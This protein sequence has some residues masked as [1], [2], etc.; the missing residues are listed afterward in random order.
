MGIAEERELSVNGTA[1]EG[2]QA[3]EILLQH[4]HV[5]LL[6]GWRDLLGQGDQEQHPPHLLQLAGEH[7][8]EKT[9]RD[10]FSS[11][12]SKSSLKCVCTSPGSFLQLS[13]M[14]GCCTPGSEDH[15]EILRASAT[16]SR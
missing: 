10:L 7:L 15:G 14:G 8:A 11:A 3:E 12:E 9:D 4:G 5:G 2:G 16:P 1:G 13:M 6:V